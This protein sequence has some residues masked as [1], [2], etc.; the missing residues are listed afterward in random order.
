M[1]LAELKEQTKELPQEQLFEFAR[2]IK[3]LEHDAW[4]AQ[5]ANDFDA[6][7]FDEIIAEIETDI[8]S[9]NISKL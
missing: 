6:G 7:K 1:S 5:I 3:E 8:Q 9:G 4:D 2:W